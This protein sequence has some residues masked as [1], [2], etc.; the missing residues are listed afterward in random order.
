MITGIKDLLKRHWPA[1]RLRSIL[2]AVLLFFALSL[3]AK[4]MFVH[5]DLKPGG[6]LEF[7]LGPN[8]SKWGQ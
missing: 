1:L 2:L 7:T 3:L 4:P 8:P 5:G 6:K